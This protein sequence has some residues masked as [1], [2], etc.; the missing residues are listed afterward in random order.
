MAR[1]AKK[2]ATTAGACKGRHYLLSMYDSQ[3]GLTSSSY[4]MNKTGVT[5]ATA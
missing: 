4:G 2:D 3:L 5:K 1:Q